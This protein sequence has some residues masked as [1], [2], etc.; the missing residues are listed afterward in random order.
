MA[1]EGP[2]D[3]PADAHGGLL[4]SRWELRRESKR[5]VFGLRRYK[6]VYLA[7]ASWTNGRNTTPDTPNPET[8]VTEPV[9][10]D[11]IEAKFQ[12]SLKFKIAQSVFGSEADLWGAYTQVS[13][14]QVYDGENSRPFRETNYEPEM[15]LVTPTDY[16]ILGWRGRLAGIGLNHQSNGRGDPL[17][18][19]WNRVVGL[20]GLDREG[21]A[22]MLRPWWRIE[23]GN[24]DDNTDISDYMGRFDIT[25]VHLRGA[26][27]FSLTGRH[28]LKDG[29]R[30][31]GAL[32]LEWAFPIRGP[33]KGRA[34]IFHGYGESMIDY[35]FKSTWV[36]LGFSLAEWF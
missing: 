24:E 13:R 28:S 20:V 3:A 14:W 21:W 2:G 27:Q 8:S 23:D 6:P 25:A 16:R 11:S 32:Q 7:P 4:D 30:S 15:M 10:L 31:H 35:N 1:R 29:R 18:R 33:L 5:G 19:S 34:S 26:H 9:D 12:L 22:L 17:S 36:T